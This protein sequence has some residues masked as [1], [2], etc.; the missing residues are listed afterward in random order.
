MQIWHGKLNQIAV[1]ACAHQVSFPG[2]SWCVHSNKYAILVDADQEHPG[3]MWKFIQHCD[4]IHAYNQVT[5]LLQA[6]A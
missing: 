2:H 4:S 3:S 1:T 6:S 5:R